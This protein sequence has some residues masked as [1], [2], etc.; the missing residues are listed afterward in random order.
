MGLALFEGLSTAKRGENST[1]SSGGPRGGRGKAKD[2]GKRS[3]TDG[4]AAWV[5][6]PGGARGVVS[7]VH[8]IRYARQEKHS[9]GCAN[10]CLGGAIKKNSI[11][12]VDGAVPGPVFANTGGGYAR[13]ATKQR[14]TALHLG[15]SY[16]IMSF[17]LIG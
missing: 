6:K 8:S 11:K 15:K 3:G 5:G 4:L 16:I 2:D 10:Q 12:V 17:A 9:D 13:M 7:R 14:H 1:E